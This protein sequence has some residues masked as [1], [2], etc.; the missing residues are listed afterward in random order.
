MYNFPNLEIK[1]QNP[2][3]YLDSKTDLY[4]RREIHRYFSRE[5]GLFFKAIFLLFNVLYIKPDS[6][7]V[8]MNV[9]LKWHENEVSQKE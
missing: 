9:I 5:K 1:I 7:L 8:F 2:D 3:F 6:Y 4:H